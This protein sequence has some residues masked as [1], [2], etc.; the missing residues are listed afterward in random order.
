MLPH[1]IPVIA[2]DVVYIGATNNF[3]YAIDAE[4]G[5]EIWQLQ[6]ESK[7]SSFNRFSPPVIDNKCIYVG[8][9]SGYLC[10]IN[11]ETQQKSW[12]KFKPKYLQLNS[13]VLADEIIY[14]ESQGAINALDAQSGEELWKFIAPDLDWWFFNPSLWKSELV[15]TFSK[16]AVGFSLIRFSSPVIADG[17]VY[18][19]CR[20]GYLYAL[21]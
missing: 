13:I 14:C 21:H 1:S 11:I 19:L 18:V 9:I 4:T 5:A 12:Q 6:V 7:Y 15:N 20:N 16:L 2:D 8:L 17:I 3:L 10:G